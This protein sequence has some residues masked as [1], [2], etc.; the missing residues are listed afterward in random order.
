L[1]YLGQLSSAQSFLSPVTVF[2]EKALVRTYYNQFETYFVL[3]PGVVWCN[4]VGYERVI[5]SYDTETD[6][7]SKR[8]KNQTGLALATGFDIRLSKGAG[9]YLRQRW[10]DYKDSSFGKDQYKGF[11][12]TAEIKVFF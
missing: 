9:L 7:I 4:Y 2:D 6:A 10:M 12:T 3:S 1:C 11:E 8:P 5:A